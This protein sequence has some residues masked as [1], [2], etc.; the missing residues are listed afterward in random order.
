MTRWLPAVDPDNREMMLS[1]GAFIENLSV[2]AGIQGYEAETD[3][4]GKDN[5]S[6]EIAELRLI[7]GKET[8]ISDRAI[9][10][11]RTVRKHLL[12]SPMREEDIKYLV[13]NNKNTVFYYPLNSK[14][15]S[16]LSEATLLANKT[17][18]YREDAQ[19][20]LAEWIRWTEQ[21]AREHHNG[22]TPESMELKGIVRWYAEH[23]L[24]KGDVLSK[25][26]RNETIKLV[27]E[28]VQ[29]CAGWLVVKSDNAIVT[30]LI[31]AGRVFQSVWLRAREKLIAFHPM[32]QVLE[33]APWLTE[34]AKELGHTGS[35]Q[36]VVRIGY[37]K[38]YLQ[39]VSLRM[40]MSKIIV[41]E[42]RYI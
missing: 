28:Q 40:P 39:P 17:Q 14:A 1:I 37:V 5:F 7:K 13:G 26:F 15:G 18:V 22:L 21:E 3:V 34:L 33:E 36:F 35:I 24:S 8:S 19:K 10:E 29:N 9:K 2:A 4:I 20:E 32:T 11:R 25:P 12:K 38:E 27:E 30:E 41:I 23:F 31:N 16:Y 6:S 42:S